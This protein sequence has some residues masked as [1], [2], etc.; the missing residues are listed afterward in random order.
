MSRSLFFSCASVKN[1]IL[2]G[3]FSFICWSSH[4]SI[5]ACFVVM[6]FIFCVMI[7]T[8]CFAFVVDLLCLAFLRPFSSGASCGPFSFSCSW[9]LSFLFWTA[10]GGFPLL[11][12]T[13]GL[14][15]SVVVSYYW[16]LL[17]LEALSECGLSLVGL[18]ACGG[19]VVESCVVVRDCIHLIL[20]FVLDYYVHH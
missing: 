4:I 7:A 10:S 16:W 20:V 13:T 14:V 3:L 5:S 18:C 12:P 9:S 15:S 1:A 6:P 2:I 11:A 19:V 17:L 8:C